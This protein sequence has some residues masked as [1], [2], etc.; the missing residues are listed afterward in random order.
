M[1]QFGG[2]PFHEGMVPK[3]QEVPFGNLRINGSLR[4]LG[5]ISRLGTSFLGS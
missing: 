5:V 3:D 2:F 1:F 4:L